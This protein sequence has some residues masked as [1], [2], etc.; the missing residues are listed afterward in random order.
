MSEQMIGNNWAQDNCDRLITTKEAAYMLGLAPTTLARARV[1]GT[2][3]Y[4][5]FIKLGKSCR[6]RMSTIRDFI[7]DQVDLVHTSQVST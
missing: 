1:Y 3:G 7:A 5:T 4:P 6:Y 2:P